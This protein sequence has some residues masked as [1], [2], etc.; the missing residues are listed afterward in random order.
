[1]NENPW[2]NHPVTPISI[3]NTTR[4]TLRPSKALIASIREDA[5]RNPGAIWYVYIGAHLYRSTLYNTVPFLQDLG[6]EHT[7]AYQPARDNPPIKSMRGRYGTGIMK[8]TGRT[9]PYELFRNARPDE[10]NWTHYSGCESDVCLEVNEAI[11]YR[12]YGRL[13][14]IVYTLA[15]Q[16]PPE[17]FGEAL[18]EHHIDW[19]GTIDILTRVGGFTE[20][21]NALKGHSM[22]L[23]WIKE[24]EEKG[25]R[26]WI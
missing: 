2:T 22:Y 14:R 1:M 18:L 3:P 12:D 26:L 15:T 4:D 16:T 6:V 19:T 13:E 11:Y 23:L 20:H 7:V 25:E 17:D 8:S 5:K 24:K 9:D 21:V 10:I